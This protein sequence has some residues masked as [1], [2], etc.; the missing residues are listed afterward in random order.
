VNAKADVKRLKLA[1]GGNS[2]DAEQKADAEAIPEA[3]TE[4]RDNGVFFIGTKVA[5]GG[6]VIEL[7]PMLLCDR[8]E[9]IGRGIDEG[10]EHYRV[11]RWQSRGTNQERMLA[12][13]LGMV[14]DRQGWAQLR[15]GGLFIAPSRRA[16]EHLASW[17]QT[18]GDDL[19]H[20]ISH[21]GGWNNGAYILPSGEVIGSP[22]SPLF[23]NGDRSH[24]HAYQ[25]KGSVESW[26]DSVARLCAG[27]SRPMLAIGAA[28]A[29]PLLHLVGLEC[30]GFHIYGPSGCGKTTSANVGASVWGHPREQ[31][32]NWDATALALA[33]AAA[34]R[35][36]GLMLLDEIGQGNPEAISMAAYRLFN[37]TGKMQ[38]ARDGGNR[39]MLRWRIL[40]LSTG[41][42]DLTGVMQGGGRRTR[43]G[44]EVRLACLPADAGAGMG[45]FDTLNGV[46]DANRLARDLDRATQENHGAV[47]RAFVA[48][49]SARLK[50]IAVRMRTAIS[51]AVDELPAEASGQVRRV[52]MR[53]AAAGEA[54][55]IA[56]EAGMTGW[57]PLEGRNA[58]R[59]CFHAWLER[60]G[61]G[62]K[63]DEQ[64]ITQAE[65]W[66]S[67]HSYS[68][69]IDWHV[70]GGDVPISMRD[71]AGYCQH[72]GDDLWFYVFPEAFRKEI[73]EG[74]DSVA[75]A[76]VLARVGMLEKGDDVATSVVRTPD[77]PKTRRFYKFVR[78][79]R[80][81]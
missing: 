38:G 51:E 53:F 68:R 78:T 40:A 65:G 76:N 4:V 57:R 63:E 81:E 22:N 56:T 75:A 26:R 23:Y 6:K 17:M 42:I 30:G 61:L 14:G 20:A 12:M 13:G 15:G 3:R 62:N 18:G 5:E 48:H 58:L 10:H 77:N 1:I 7:P 73:A 41:E 55:E 45:C 31:V 66:F 71:V 11:L 24:S 47:G 21:R 35:N 39:E 69:F 60:Y 64:I 46:P 49:V 25:P 2:A 80:A 44:Q 19:M 79:T 33:N 72:K 67:K 70:A 36:D 8:L 74:F 32:L 54:L 50:D 43:A 52:A 27:N 16:Q 59:R 9:I 37:G 34:A 28:L 29:A